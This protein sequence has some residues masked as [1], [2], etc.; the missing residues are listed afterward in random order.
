MCLVCHRVSCGVQEAPPMTEDMVQ[1]RQT[2]LAALGTLVLCCHTGCT[3]SISFQT[4]IAL[5]LVSM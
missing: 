1:D 5:G 2:A 4:I 3:F